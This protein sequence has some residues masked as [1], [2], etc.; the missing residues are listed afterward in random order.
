MRRI[1]VIAALTTMALGAAASSADTVSPVVG[2]SEQVGGHD[3]AYWTVA[4]DRWR[5]AQQY[6]GQAG[7]AQCRVTGQSGPVWFISSNALGQHVSTVFCAVP[8]D[9]YVMLSLPAIVCSNFTRIG[10]KGTVPRRPHD[11]RACARQ[12]WGHYGDPH[13]R[14][15]VDGTAITPPGAFVLTP[16]FS[17]R[18]PAHRNGFRVD[19][20]TRGRAAHAGIVTMLRPLPPGPHKIVVGTQF[21]HDHNRVVIVRLTVG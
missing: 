19:G 17:F 20:A 9:R 10:R 21:R 8:S 15:V 13:P 11:I 2:G 1:A 16:V 5:F 6:G 14:V 18:M 12:F 7:D 4:S 3:L